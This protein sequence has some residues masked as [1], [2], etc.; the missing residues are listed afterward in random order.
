MRTGLKECQWSCDQYGG[1]GN[2]N[3]CGNMKAVLEKVMI[4]MMVVLMMGVVVMV[5][6]L[7]L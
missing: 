5:T 2:L 6:E 4:V 3:S 7:A 1:D